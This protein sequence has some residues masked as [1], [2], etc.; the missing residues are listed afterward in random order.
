MWFSRSS[1]FG[2]RGRVGVGRRSLGPFVVA[3]EGACA[4]VLVLLEGT[5]VAAQAGLA[6]TFIR[7]A[8]CPLVALNADV[9]WDPLDEDAPV[10]ECAV[11]EFAHS[12]HER[13][14]GFGFVV[15]G[16]GQCGVRAV[17]E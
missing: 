7:Q 14:V 6:G 12:V 9:G 11:V 16:D 17:G 8:V 4:A 3:G 15:F 10:L 2:G 1:S 5:E 13:A